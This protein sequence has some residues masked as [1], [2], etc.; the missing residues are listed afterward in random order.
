MTDDV[1]GKE[2]ETTKQSVLAATRWRE[3]T[4]SEKAPYLAKAEQ[5]K[6]RYEEARRVYEA[7]QAEGMLPIDAAAHAAAAGKAAAA[8]MNET[9]PA[10]QNLPLGL[11]GELDGHDDIGLGAASHG[12]KEKK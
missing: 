3:L 7:A 6:T 12:K 10:L 11:R 2:S 5:D 1:F 4:D 9:H 8:K